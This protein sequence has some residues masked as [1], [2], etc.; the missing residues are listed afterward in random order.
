MKIDIETCSIT[1]N[2]LWKFISMNS[3]TTIDI[4]ERYPNKPWDWHAISKNPN[5]NL[6]FI[7]KH[8]YKCIDWESISENGDI[9]DEL[10]E[11]FPDEI[12]QYGYIVL[13]TSLLYNLIKKSYY[14]RMKEKINR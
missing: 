2:I 7:E 1:D 6:Q 13:D 3:D 5:I 14:K 8:H 10:F 4:I 9:L 11:R 12:T